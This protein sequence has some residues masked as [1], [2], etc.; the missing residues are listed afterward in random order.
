[1]L[2]SKWVERALVLY[3][4]K[5][6]GPGKLATLRSRSK[7]LMR[8]GQGKRVGKFGGEYIWQLRDSGDLLVC[9]KLTPNAVPRDVEKCL[10]RE[11]EEVYQKFR[12]ANINR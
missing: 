11:F 5:A 8:F 10:I 3:V 12:F 4:G 6:G 7:N 2:K 1:V 9:W